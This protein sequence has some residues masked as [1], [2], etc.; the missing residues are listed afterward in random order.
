[1][2]DQTLSDNPRIPTD[3]PISD[4]APWYESLCLGLY[5][6]VLALTT[7]YLLVATWPISNSN[8]TSELGKFSI[9]GWKDLS[10]EA[11]QRLMVT[12]ILAGALGSLIHS[13]T[14][15]A[16]YVGNHRLGRSWI[17]YLVLRTPAGIAL[18]L[19][20]YF[21]LRGG[22]IVPSLPNGSG[23]TNTT[24]LLNPYGIAAI[25]ALAGMF[26]KQ[27]TDKLREIFDTL[28]RTREPVSRADPLARAKPVISGTEPAKLA[29]GGPVALS[30]LG[31]GFH[32]DCTASVSGTARPVEW[33]S[34][35]RLAVTLLPQDIAQKTEIRLVIR[36]P[37]P[38]GGDT[39][40]FRVP[41]E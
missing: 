19:L 39:E 31:Q 35:T 29:V 7:F 28:F 33:Q 38:A 10:L 9:F 17:W 20:F 40:I 32:R 12:V 6:V 4:A 13:I 41:V 16:D 15:F 27:A 23:Q 5:F 1:M 21:V 30:V 22:L 2:N 34:E 18:A 37:G 8:N 11:D 25:A 24:N 26:S 36:N 14:S 3:T